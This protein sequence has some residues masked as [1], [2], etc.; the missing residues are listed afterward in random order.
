MDNLYFIPNN[1]FTKYFKELIK[2]KNNY[3]QYLNYIYIHTHTHIQELYYAF[4]Y[5]S[6]SI[7]MHMHGVTSQFIYK[8][9]LQYLL[10][11]IKKITNR[12]NFFNWFVILIIL[13][14]ILIFKYN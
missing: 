2:Y 10:Y 12:I 13:S 14:G 7:S 1:I 9:T 4:Y 5:I 3:Q 6:L 11:V 8:P